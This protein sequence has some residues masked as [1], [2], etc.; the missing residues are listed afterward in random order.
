MSGRPSSYT[1]EIADE[2][3]AQLA[4]GRSLRTVCKAETMPS[5]P[6]VF[7]WMRRFPEFLNQYARAKEESADYLAEETLE[8]ADDGSNDWITSNDPDNAGYR[9]NGEHIARS[10]LR[11]D[12][13]KWIAS[14]LKP[15]KY[16]EKLDVAHSGSIETIS[17]ESL[18]ERLTSLYSTAHSRLDGNRSEGTAGADAGIPKTH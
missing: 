13:R 16:G 3:C 1:Q 12:T 14:K 7:S 15:K 18:I 5:V 11:V 6:T 10:R 9:A 17:R 8:I 2:I 4:E